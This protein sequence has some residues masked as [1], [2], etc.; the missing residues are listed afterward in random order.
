MEAID[1]RYP[2]G[3]MVPVAYSKQEF[4][5]K[6]DALKNLPDNLEAALKG[7][8]TDQLNTPY[9]EGGWTVK[10]L[11]HHIAD[12]HTNAYGRIVFALDEENPSIKPY[13]ENSWALL[14]D[15]RGISVENSV[16]LIRLVHERLVQLASTLT[17]SEVN[18]TVYHPERQRTLSIWDLL[19]IYAWHSKHHVAHILMLRK[20]QNW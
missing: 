8:S 5:A 19:S 16:G 18:R 7:L 11:V 4:D 12:S 17:E 20:N 9:R 3:K 6:I 14:A 2:V 10:Q 13:N 1:P 15:K